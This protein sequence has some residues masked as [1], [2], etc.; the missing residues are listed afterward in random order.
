[1]KIDKVILGVFLMASIFINAHAKGV[2]PVLAALKANEKIFVVER[3]N[4]SLAVIEQGL[5]RGHIEGMHDM[6]HGVVKFYG[7]DG[8]VISRDGYI[9]K[10]EAG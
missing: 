8:Y 9:I 6:N 2:N 5:T 4:Q 3:E 7:K 1:M 10:F